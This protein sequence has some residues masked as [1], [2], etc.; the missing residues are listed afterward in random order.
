MGIFAKYNLSRTMA[1]SLEYG[2]RFTFT[3]YIDDVSG[4]IY[5]PA[6]I[7][8]ANGGNGDAAAYFSNPTTTVDTDEGPFILANGRNIVGQQRG[9]AQSNDT[10]MFTVLALNY[11][12][13]SK[14]TN[15]PKF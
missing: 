9:N 2:F 5:D 1:I 4:Y 12:F 15:R 11:K 7:K 13:V 8:A 3:D 10:Y 6:K 14:K